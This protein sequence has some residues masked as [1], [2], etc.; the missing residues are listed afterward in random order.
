MVIMPP[1]REDIVKSF[2]YKAV[3]RNANSSVS[4]YTK[5]CIRRYDEE[6]FKKF[7]VGVA[8]S[9]SLVEVLVRIAEEAANSL[10]DSHRYRR[11]WRRKGKTRN[12][13]DLHDRKAFNHITVCCK[14][15][16]E[17]VWEYYRFYRAL[18]KGSNLDFY[19]DSK[20]EDIPEVF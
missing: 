2:F 12:A 9:P 7:L 1:T 16:R 14:G 17:L 3:A 11:F 18:R 5:E 8:N 13:Y 20:E 10:E 19:I 15:D 4:E 6:R